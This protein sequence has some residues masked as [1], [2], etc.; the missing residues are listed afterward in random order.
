MKHPLLDD[1][2]IIAWDMDGT[3]VNGPN[4]AF[5]RSYILANPEKTHVV[6]TFRTP[7]AWAED[8]YRE[9]APFGI[10]RE[11]ITAVHNV[12]DDL[13]HA[14][15]QRETLRTPENLAKVERYYAYKGSKAKEIG[16]TVMIDDI[17]A[18]VEA[19]CVTHGIK[20]IDALGDFPII[21]DPA[22]VLYRPNG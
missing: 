9:L 5:F 2:A 15:A 18:H 12:E 13:Y 8:V 14:Y 4:S 17:A 21:D 10:T 1:H 6:I 3:L 7:R 11:H 16:A 22:G 20:F 19:G